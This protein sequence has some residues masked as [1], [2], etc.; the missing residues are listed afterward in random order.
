MNLNIYMFN[1]LTIHLF[2]F[3]MDNFMDLYII[4]CFI[5]YLSIYST[6]QWMI[7]WIYILLHV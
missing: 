5:I 2:N 4:T 7:L 1:Y 6:L 3:T